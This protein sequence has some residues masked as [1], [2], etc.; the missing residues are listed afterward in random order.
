MFSVKEWPKPETG[1]KQTA[2]P[3][4]YCRLTYWSTPKEESVRYSETSVSFYRN[5]R[6]HIPETQFFSAVA[7]FLIACDNNQRRSSTSMLDRLHHLNLQNEKIRNLCQS[8]CYWGH[9]LKACEFDAERRARGKGQD[10]LYCG[11]T[12][13]RNEVTRE[14]ITDNITEDLHELVYEDLDWIQMTQNLDV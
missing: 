12:I 10:C 14:P 6:H 5:L 3:A 1:E 9:R 4:P 7:S 11:Q 8:A 13:R 2:Q